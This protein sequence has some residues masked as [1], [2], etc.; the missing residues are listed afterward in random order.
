M[1]ANINAGAQKLNQHVSPLR[2][3]AQKSIPIPVAQV[4]EF[5][6][7]RMVEEFEDFGDTRGRGAHKLNRATHLQLV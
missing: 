4:F 6:K 5:W 2:I 3:G 1:L 7:F